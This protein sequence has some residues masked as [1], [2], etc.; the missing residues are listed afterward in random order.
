LL[1]FLALGLGFLFPVNYG[2]C[3]CERRGGVAAAGAV[4]RK[5]WLLVAVI[6]SYAIVQQYIRRDQSMAKF[7]LA[8]EMCSSDEEHAGGMAAAASS[9]LTP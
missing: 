7:F 8:C 5:G 3:G 6:N 9:S 2:A 4:A 1:V